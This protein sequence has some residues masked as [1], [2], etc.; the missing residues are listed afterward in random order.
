MGPRDDDHAPRPFQAPVGA[1]TVL[2]LPAEAELP[3]PLWQGVLLARPVGGWCWYVCLGGEDRALEPAF[4]FGPPA[5]AD[6]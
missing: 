3:E 5:P 4:A 2:L 1:F 6:C